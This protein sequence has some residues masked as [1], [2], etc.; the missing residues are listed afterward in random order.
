MFEEHVIFPT[1]LS[2]LLTESA[3]HSIDIAIVAFVMSV[4]LVLAIVLVCLYYW[5]IR[6]LPARRQQLQA[7]M[8]QSLSFSVRLA[9]PDVER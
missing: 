3:T 7:M 5:H 4:L 1:S 2:H 6:T 8:F 9:A